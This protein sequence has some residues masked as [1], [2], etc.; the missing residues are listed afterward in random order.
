MKEKFV[1]TDLLVIGGGLGGTF[2]AL[3]AREASAQKITLISKG[4]L[5]KDS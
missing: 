1:E 4:K 3:K 5:G 2:A